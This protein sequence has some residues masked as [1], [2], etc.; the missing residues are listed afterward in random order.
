MKPGG[1]LALV[2]WNDPAHNEWFTAAAWGARPRA[3]AADPAAGHARDR[4]GWPIREH[5]RGVLEAAGFGRVAFDDVEV[6]FWFGPDADAAFEFAP[7]DR[8]RAGDDRQ[9]ST[10][11]SVPRRSTPSAR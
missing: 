5:T 1:R 3:V 6:P 2:V 4:T 10:T 11:T 8:V 9:I 7:R